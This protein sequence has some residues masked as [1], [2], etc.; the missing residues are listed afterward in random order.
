MVMREVI[1][2]QILLIDHHIGDIILIMVHYINFILLI[3]IYQVLIIVVILYS[4][5][6]VEHYLQHIQIQLTIQQI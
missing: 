6:M 3:G 2:M 1:L 5:F 4:M